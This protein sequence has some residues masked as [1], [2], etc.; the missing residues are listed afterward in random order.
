[1]SGEQPEAAL[2]EDPSGLPAEMPTEG[3]G[4]A[5][6]VQ[7]PV[8]A[9]P[10]KRTPAGGKSFLQQALITIICGVLFALLLQ[11]TMQNYVVEGESMLP[12]VRPDDRVLI[13]RLAYRLGDPQR[14][15]VV[16]FHF[17]YSSQNEDFIKRIIGLPGDTVTVE[18]G[19]LLVNGKVVPEPEITNIEGYSYGPQRVPQGQYFVLGD[20]RPV[21]Y[22]SHS[23]GFLPRKELYGR[24]MIT[25]W[26]VGDF[27]LFGF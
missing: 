19:R 24:V 15:D 13:N 5:D 14:G 26:P 9:A 10:A 4:L 12:N 6:A 11:I 2:P 18:P 27:H 23:W 1:M 3:I 25:Y 16:V 7:A 17:P 21:S 22:D 20:N 8:A